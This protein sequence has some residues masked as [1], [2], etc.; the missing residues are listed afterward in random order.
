[1]LF[2]VH[3]SAPYQASVLC[4]LPKVRAHAHS[5]VVASVK[6]CA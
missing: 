2:V 4:I 5:T 3:R 6:S 1:M